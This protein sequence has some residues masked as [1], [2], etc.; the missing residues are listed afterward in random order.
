MKIK[1]DSCLSNQKEFYGTIF[2]ESEEEAN[3]FVDLIQTQDS[4]KVSEVK[5]KMSNSQLNKT[6]GNEQNKV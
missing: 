3:K 1:I 6:G 5:P 4:I 2:P